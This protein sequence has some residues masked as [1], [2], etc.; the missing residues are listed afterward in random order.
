MAN[1]YHEDSF[2]PILENA[3]DASEPLYWEPSEPNIKIAF[4]QHG[5]RRAE[6]H[7][8][9][10]KPPSKNETTPCSYS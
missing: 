6:R 9:I 2:L 3:P 8:A 1:E 5:G 7:E 10:K 4:D